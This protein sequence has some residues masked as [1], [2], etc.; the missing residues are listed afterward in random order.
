MRGD[1][2]G[3]TCHCD[4]ECS[5]LPSPL[6]CE[7][8]EKWMLP[9][10]EVRVPSTESKTSFPAAPRRSSGTSH[11]GAG[12]DADGSTEQRQQDSLRLRGLSAQRP[13]LQREGS[14]PSGGLLFASSKDD[15]SDR[16]EKTDRCGVTE[17]HS[18]ERRAR[19]QWVP[20]VGLACLGESESQG[21]VQIKRVGHRGDGCPSW[22]QAGLHDD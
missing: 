2:G 20:S 19:V 10:S 7:C 22:D 9:D 13:C 12:G 5:K 6:R 1:G 15:C 14:A 16:F 17:N 3:Y 8:A 11:P 21:T 18:G 4:S